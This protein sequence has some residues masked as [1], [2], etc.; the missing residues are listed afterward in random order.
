MGA[1]KE[2]GLLQEEDLVS[3]ESCLGARKK[4]RDYLEQTQLVPKPQVQETLRS[5]GTPVLQKP[6]SSAEL[7][8]RSEIHCSDLKSLDIDIPDDRGVYEP[9]EISVKYSGY[10]KRQEE[11]IAQMRKLEEFVLPREMCFKKISGLSHEEIE[12]LSQIK[13]RTLGQA[14]RISGVNPSA[15]Q[16][17]LVH[18]KA[19]KGDSKR[20]SF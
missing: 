1:S 15:I 18:M 5:L 11:F 17:L 14:Q 13:P 19:H 6:M 20:K 4:F 12:K 7:L 2:Y 8:R 10:I 3:L 9:V 16:A